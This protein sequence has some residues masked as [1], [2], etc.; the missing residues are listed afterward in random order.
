VVG[1]VGLTALGKLN[2]PTDVGKLATR[3]HMRAYIGS[4]TDFEA[5]RIFLTAI[6]TGADALYY[7]QIGDGNSVVAGESSPGITYTWDLLGDSHFGVANNVATAMLA[8]IKHVIVE[9]HVFMFSLTRS[10]GGHLRGSFSRP[11]RGTR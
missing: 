6:G 11:P 4:I 5:S 8:Q 3:I 10:V 7:L 1:G 2:R 9:Y